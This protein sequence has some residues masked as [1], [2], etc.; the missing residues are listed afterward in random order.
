[1]KDILINE[2]SKISSGLIDLSRAVR[3]YATALP[4]K[5]NAM[6]A[7]YLSNNPIYSDT[8]IR[9]MKYFREAFSYKFQL[10]TLYLEELWSLTHIGDYQITL[11]DVLGNI[12]DTHQFVNDGLLLPSFVFEGFIVQG[13]TFLDFYMLYMCSIFKIDETKRLNGKKF[14][15]ALEL[16]VDDPY[17]DRAQ[18]V[19]QYF[20]EN[21]FGER[22]NKTIIT[23]N[24]G[25]LLRRLRNSIVHR[26]ILIPDFE[27]NVTLLEKI[28]GQ[29]TENDVDLPCSRFSQDVQNVIFYLITTLAGIVYD[30]EWKPGPYKPGMWGY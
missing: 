26:D 22:E 10:S 11:K 2:Y 30:L 17:R 5:L 8:E 21:V 4:E 24:W 27:N 9:R 13:S 1:M 6:E 20:E 18:K 15:N 25:E 23:N 3:N 14:L 16:V 19:R 7:I 28:I 29:W 12:F